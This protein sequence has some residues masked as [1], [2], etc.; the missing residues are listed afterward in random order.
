MTDAFRAL[1]NRLAMPAFERQL[2]LRERLGDDPDWHLKV[3]EGRAQFDGRAYPIQLLGTR[4]DH[5]DTW[6]WAWDG[7][8]SAVPEALLEASKKVKKV[9]KKRLCPELAES[10]FPL[11]PLGIDAHALA[12]VATGLAELPAYF[13]FPYSGGALFAALD[14]PMELPVPS[15]ERLDE[16]VRGVTSRLDVD[17]RTA[18]ESYLRGRG[19]DVDASRAELTARWPD[20]ASRTYR[21]SEGGQL[22]A[23]A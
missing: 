4:A 8:A 11:E 7:A 10:G 3:G 9:G 15:P 6:R 22:A 20:G 18:V 5:D 21:F 16:I 23:M 2:A 14:V 12:L 17:A 1:L 19:I 13:R